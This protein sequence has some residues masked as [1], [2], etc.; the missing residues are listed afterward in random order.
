LKKLTTLILTLFLI[1]ISNYCTFADDTS[2][3]V[4]LQTAK[5][6]DYD[7]QYYYTSANVIEP[8]QDFYLFFCINDPT[9][10]S[11]YNFKLYYNTNLVE[12]VKDDGTGS[13]IPLNVG[14]SP[15]SF[16]S[17]FPSTSYIDKKNTFDLETGEITYSVALSSG[18]VFPTK[19][20]DPYYRLASMHFR[21]KQINAVDSQ[22]T[23]FMETDKFKGEV[24]LH[25]KVGLSVAYSINIT[26]IINIHSFMPVLPFPPIATYEYNFEKNKWYLTL[27]KED[28]PSV[29]IWYTTTL[30]GSPVEYTI[31]ILLDEAAIIYS[32]TQ[33]IRGSTTAGSA[34]I[35]FST[36]TVAANPPPGR[37]DT[38]PESISL[39]SE[40]GGYD[41]YY[42][43]DNTVTDTAN[44]TKY[45]SSTPITFPSN[46]NDLT[47]KTILGKNGDLI[48]SNFKT[49]NYSIRPNAPVAN[50]NGGPHTSSVAVEF[51]EIDQLTKGCRIYYTLDGTTDPVPPASDEIAPIPPTIKYDGISPINI[52][53][54]C[55]LKAIAVKDNRQS[56]VSQFTYTINPPSS[57][58]GGGG[59]GGSTIIYKYISV[60]K[61]LSELKYKVIDG[62]A[63][64]EIPNIEGKLS[65]DYIITTD[66][67]QD[68][69]EIK[70]TLQHII[71]GA[72]GLKKI[73]INTKTDSF[74]L[75]FYNIDYPLAVEASKGIKPID[76]PVTLTYSR[77]D[78]ESSLIDNANLIK[79]S[80]FYSYKLTSFIDKV[81][82]PMKYL[83]GYAQYIMP[84]TEVPSGKIPL[85]VAM[86]GNIIQTPLYLDR[87]TAGKESVVLR[88]L[89]DHPVCI[90][91]GDKRT[92]TDIDGN[93][94]QKSIERLSTMRIVNGRPEGFTPD[95]NI[96]RAELSAM[97][98]R[99][100]GAVMKDTVA[101]AFSDLDK[102]HWSYYE[103]NN[104][105]K[106]GLIHGYPDFT[107]KPEQSVTRLETIQMIANALSYTNRDA[108]VNTT[109]AGKYLSKIKD[110]EDIESWAVPSVVMVLKYEIIKGYEDGSL[111]PNSPITRAETVTLIGRLLENFKLI[112]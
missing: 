10:V 67:P 108:F 32:Y 3:E 23:F 78:G 7:D 97:I 75:P 48:G 8:G 45:S 112:N 77:K 103:A 4:S 106:W 44:F 1:T 102:T 94:S 57:G 62:K 66:A 42:T 24:A 31:P 36:P 15:V 96:T 17:L 72:K 21:A 109:E 29:K 59:G 56:D 18:A 28:D 49:L 73:I 26:K 65:G 46:S 64:Y 84:M 110:S 79:D 52:T 82:F 83:V 98:S 68:E 27:T 13:L 104:A 100:M 69:I 107:F 90:V 53:S 47:I 80:I 33:R 34:T 54:S 89:S 92:Y 58:G 88:A 85:G 37:Y 76:V 81:A 87:T 86:N 39:Y 14:D 93:W 70:F 71:D 5:T 55:T 25:N 6:L 111:R 35:T 2:Y 99:A 22:A 9:E 101:T 12:L 30:G 60:E 38:A 50:P 20:E 16:S 105:Q 74:I 43:I 51:R 11:G 41:V 91:Y 19:N 40:P 95:T 61:I 63:V